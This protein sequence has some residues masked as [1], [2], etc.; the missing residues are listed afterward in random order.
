MRAGSARIP[1][2][3]GG[4][5]H[6]KARTLGTRRLIQRLR[7][8]RTDGVRVSVQRRRP[9]KRDSWSRGRHF[10]QQVRT[11]TPDLLDDFAGKA[12]R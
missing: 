7:R 8:V 4:P 11:A 12:G 1:G 3:F 6:Q 10:R 5:I 2:R 9:E